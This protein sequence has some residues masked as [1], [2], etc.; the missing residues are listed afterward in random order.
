LLD[1]LREAGIIHRERRGSVRVEIE[2]TRE[3]KMTDM[4]VLKLPPVCT[5]FVCFTKRE[6]EKEF[7][8]VVLKRGEKKEMDLRLRDLTKEVDVL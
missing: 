5:R 6:W 1:L 3:G 2:R 8:D 7:P 4:Y